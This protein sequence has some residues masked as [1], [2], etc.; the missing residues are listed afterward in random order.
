MRVLHLYANY[1]WTGP[2]DLALQVVQGQAS[3]SAERGIEAALAIAAWKH[4]GAEHAIAARAQALDLPLVHGLHLRKHFHPPSLLADARRLAEWIDD[5]RLDLIHCHQ[6]GDHLLAA[7][8]LGLAGRR[9]PL[10]RSSWEATIPAPLPRAGLMFGRTAAMTVAFDDLRD[11]VTGRYGIPSPRVVKVE[12][13]LDDSFFRAGEQEAMAERAAL[14]EELGLPSGALLIGITA[15]IQKRRRWDLL[16]E[17]MARVIEGQ[18]QA[19]LTV[20]GRPDEGVFEEV[21]SRPIEARGLG[22]RV[23][24]LGYRRDEAYL[25]VLR[26][27]DVFTFLVPGSD[28]TCRALREAMGAGLPV[29]TT[30]L[31]RLPTLVEDGRSG[32]V[33]RPDAGALALALDSLLRDATLR[34]TMGECARRHAVERWS[35]RRTRET[36]LEVYESIGL[37]P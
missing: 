9:V 19:H 16:W 17:T 22:A 11:Q 4:E 23:H 32:C 26:G 18:P 20:L 27:V 25:R 12:P 15:R 34:R 1:K 6:D 2:A 5:H 24:F 35:E 21:C 29:V 8:A 30:D 3:L 37:S 10:V 33:C 13:P 36:I 31:G 14:R 28:A 7:L